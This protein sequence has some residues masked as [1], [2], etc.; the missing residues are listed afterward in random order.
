MRVSRRQLLSRS[1]A[2]ALEVVPSSQIVLVDGKSWER[3]S[4]LE[5]IKSPE[6]ND[7]YIRPYRPLE[8]AVSVSFDAA[9]R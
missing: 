4:V 3:L 2:F 8:P 1:S 5:R 7:P 6:V 9:V